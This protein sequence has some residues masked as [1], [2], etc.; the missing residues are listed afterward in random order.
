MPFVIRDKEL[1]NQGFGGIYGVGKV[2]LLLLNL[3]EFFKVN[4]MFLSYFR[5]L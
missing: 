4:F 5:L 2:S 3:C 1:E